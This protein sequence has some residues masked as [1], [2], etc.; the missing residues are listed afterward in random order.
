MQVLQPATRPSQPSRA[1][2]AD[3][4][5][6]LPIDLLSPLPTTLA[7]TTLEPSPL[8]S[9]HQQH[10]HFRRPGILLS[11]KVLPFMEYCCQDRSF[12]HLDRPWSVSTVE[13]N[14]SVQGVHY[15]RMVLG[16]VTHGRCALKAVGCRHLQ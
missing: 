4:T 1:Q 14:P 11:Q 5:A 15:S 6:S 2:S 3:D 12:T 10:T 8:L 13:T 16:F 9:Q 7:T